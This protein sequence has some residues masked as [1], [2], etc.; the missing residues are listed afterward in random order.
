MFWKTSISTY[1]ILPT[2]FTLSKIYLIRIKGILIF[3]LLGKYYFIPASWARGTCRGTS[4][5]EISAPSCSSPVQVPSV[6][7]GRSALLVQEALMSLFHLL[8]PQN[9]FVKQKR[10]TAANSPLYSCPLM[11]HPQL[12]SNLI[13]SWQQASCSLR[14]SKLIAFIITVVSHPICALCHLALLIIH[15]K[16][17]DTSIHL[18]LSVVYSAGY[19]VS[20]K[21]VFL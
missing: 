1:Q 20:T 4:Q 18:D 6:L 7:E 3:W 17:T 21:Y 2:S 19:Y 9:L 13:F 5:E 16:Y 11:H 14:E 15:L 10:I 12:P 8:Q